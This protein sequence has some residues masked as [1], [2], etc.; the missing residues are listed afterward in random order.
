M[1]TS[2]TNHISHPG[3]CVVM[4]VERSFISQIRVF[5]HPLC[6]KNI[7]TDVLLEIGESFFFH[8]RLFSF[9]QCLFLLS[10]TTVLQL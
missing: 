5:L 7:G 6:L 3:T 2:S 9:F 8:F 1:G 4:W 10:D